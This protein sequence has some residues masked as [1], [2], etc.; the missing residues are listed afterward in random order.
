[1]KKQIR[2][3]YAQQIQKG[4]KSALNLWKE[5]AVFEAI[6]DLKNSIPEDK[7][8]KVRDKAFTLAAIGEETGFVKGFIYAVRLFAEC[9]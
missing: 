6:Q 5:E 8:E 4:E 3:I 7:Y 2:E 1:M 9:L